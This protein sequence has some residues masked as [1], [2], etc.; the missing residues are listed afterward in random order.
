MYIGEGINAVV[1]LLIASF[2]IDR[3]VLSLMFMLSWIKWWE[4]KFPDPRVFDDKTGQITA[5][6]KQKLLYFLLAGVFAVVVLAKFSDILFFRAFE[7]LGIKTPYWLDVLITGIILMGGSDI[8][9]RVLKLA[10]ISGGG[11][12]DSASSKPVEISGT[13]VLADRAQTT[14]SAP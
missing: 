10:G 11:T 7:S 14:Q 12:A 9:G 5:E 1:V 2:A 3:V 4:G 8:V 13:L 6:R